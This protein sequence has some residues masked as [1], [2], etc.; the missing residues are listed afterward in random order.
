MAAYALIGGRSIS[1][2]S[3]F[4]LEEKIFSHL[5]LKP[6]Q[7]LFIPLAAYPNMEDAIRKFK[8]LV[9]KSYNV[10]YLTAFKDFADIVLDIDNSDVIYFSGGCAEELVRLVKEY[11][12]DEILEAYK[13]TDKLFM[14][15]SAGAILFSKAGMGDRY[16][17]K[18]RGNIYN[19]QMVEGLGILPITICPHYDHD[20]LECYN[21]EV[22]GYTFD[23][24]A[25]EDDTA[26]LIEDDIF[27]LKQDSKKSVYLF[28]SKNG[29]LMKPLYEVEK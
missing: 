22:K 28:D 19:Y 4:T 9:P 16:S 29:Y 15:I 1:H 24:Y 21:E 11:R 14:G 20:G 2:L 18:D 3:D 5:H 13:E 17:Y 23:G 25:I 6:K 10:N 8:A 27:V 26:I 12:M 7:I